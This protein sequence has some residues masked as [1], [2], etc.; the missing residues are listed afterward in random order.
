[1]DTVADHHL[2]AEVERLCPHRRLNSPAVLC[3]P[4]WSNTKSIAGD[5]LLPDDKVSNNKDSRSRGARWVKRATTPLNDR[6]YLPPSNARLAGEGSPECR[7]QEV[8]KQ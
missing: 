4:P 2:V 8:G 7:R 6:R 3:P 5:V 1:M